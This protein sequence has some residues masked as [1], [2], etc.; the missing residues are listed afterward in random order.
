MAQNREKI[1]ELLEQAKQGVK[2]VFESDRYR[3][4][5][6]AIAKFHRYSSRNVFLIL[7]QCPHATNVAGYVAWQ[8]K[9]NR[10]VQKGETGIKILGYAPETIT[11]QQIRTD[12]S[13]NAVKDDKG[14]P[15]V[16]IV[17]KQIP[18]FAPMC[19]F[20]VSQTEG[21]PLPQLVHE[22]SG[23][24]DA[25]ENLMAAISEVSPYQVV[26]EEMAG[27]KKG[28][29]DSDTE[30]IAVKSGM[31]EAQTLK[32]VIHEIT[33][34]EL[35]T[36]TEGESNGANRGEEEVQA[37]ST[38]F[39][40][41]SRFGIDTSDYSFSYLAAWS[42]TK[43]LD[44]LQSSLNVI[45]KQAADLIDRIDARLAELQKSRDLPAK[46]KP[47]HASM[48]DRFAAAEAESERRTVGCQTPEPQKIQERG[49]A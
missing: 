5:L 35:H 4:Y 33:H 47:G 46:Q 1:N 40:V 17:K 29:C 20:D 48:K 15:V 6:S 19:V 24:V 11:E 27:S 38:A 14:N 12:K 7:A 18:A 21:E 49:G 22:L 36:N 37:E 39:I 8:K 9:F 42:S 34:A 10:H 3:E 43:E 44:E 23:D 32:T 30:K 26:F 2:K 28:Y 13:G 25:Y 31:S 45:Q 16:D 41:C